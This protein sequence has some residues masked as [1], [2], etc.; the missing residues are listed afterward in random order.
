VLS[1]TSSATSQVESS[2]EER[3]FTRPRARAP[4]SR[5]AAS[6]RKAPSAATRNGTAKVPRQPT[7][8]AS[9]P[10]STVPAAPP[11]PMTALTTPMAPVTR[12][13]GRASRS[14]P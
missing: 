1:G 6:V 10:A 4:L 13:R 11:M 14:S 9:G 8:S 3:V 7:R 5:T 12:S 2:T